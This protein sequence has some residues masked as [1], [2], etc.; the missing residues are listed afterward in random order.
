VIVFEPK[1][2]TVQEMRQRLREAFAQDPERSLLDRLKRKF[3]DPLQPEDEAGRPRIYSLW[4]ILG[5]AALAAVGLFLYLG[6]F[7]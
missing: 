3:L 6:F 1:Q 5:L 4:L 7:Q 2:L